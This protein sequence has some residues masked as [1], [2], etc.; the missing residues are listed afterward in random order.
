MPAFLSLSLAL[1]S[2][3]SVH[4]VP[5]SGS[6]GHVDV[7]SGEGSD[8]RLHV[9]S[10]CP[11]P[12]PQTCCMSSHFLLQILF[13]CLNPRHSFEVVKHVEAFHSNY[14]KTERS[15]ELEIE[16]VLN[17]AWEETIHHLLLLFFCVAHYFRIL[18]AVGRYR[19]CL[20]SLVPWCHM[21]F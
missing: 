20:V 8:P 2:F 9:S 1:S 17:S 15:K 13:A 18:D 12:T 19:A 14:S 16:F 4:R 7:C 3:L 10:H 21:H 11:H 6:G 5:C